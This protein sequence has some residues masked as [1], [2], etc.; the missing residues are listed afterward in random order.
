[1]A[2]KKAP[3]LGAPLWMVTFADLLASV[4][5]FF[6]ILAAYSTMDKQK[7][8]IVAGSMREAFG[9][10]KDSRLAGLIERD[11]I[12]TRTE[13]LNAKVRPLNEA[14]EMTGPNG[15]SLETES[16]I[17]GS[18]RAA[19]AAASLRQ[20]LQAMPEVSDLSRHIMLERSPEGVQLS[21]VDQD[22]RSM[23][24]EGSAQP[25]E[26]VRVLLEA[27]GPTL[28]RLPNRI[29]ISGHTAAL[30]SGQRAPVSPW[31]IS[32]SRAAAVQEILATAGVPNDRFASVTGRADTDLKFP[33]NPYLAANRRVTITLLNEPP[34][35][36]AGLKP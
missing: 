5:A 19:S 27:L 2:K 6:V 10:V 23:F 35:L 4:L 11:G 15:K 32:V 7:L 14:A 25:F 36:P 18:D 30:R 29:A 1:M 26:R 13:L 8:Q 31:E 28:R 33:D 12:P 9:T 20:A 24:P 17:N 21:L 22:G 16:Q 34:P 3:P